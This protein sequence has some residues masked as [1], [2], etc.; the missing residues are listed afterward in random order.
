MFAGLQFEHSSTLVYLKGMY[1]ILD[2]LTLW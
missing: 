2:L 1:L